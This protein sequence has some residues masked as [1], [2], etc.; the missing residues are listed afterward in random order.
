LAANTTGTLDTAAGVNA[1]SNNTTGQS[2]TAVGVNVMF[3]STT[4]SNNIAVGYRAGFNLTVGSNDIDVSNPGV[5]AESNT[6]RIGTQGAQKATFIAGI[7]NTGVTGADVLISSTGQLGVGPPSSARFKRD[8]HDME[9]ASSSLMRLRPVTF[10]YKNDPANTRQYGL[11]AEEVAKV[12]PELVVYGPDRKILTVRYS[13]LSAMLLNELQKQSR[14]NQRQAGQIQQLT[15][16]SAEQAERSEQQAV[17]NRRLSAQVAK[18]KGMFEQAMA[19]QRGA[20]SLAAAFN[21]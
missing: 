11:V 2:N 7:N 20:R 1:L 3:N 14:E 9:E 8:I 4:G 21:R 16:R 5:A 13:M 15:E 6:I 18:L 12:Y 10:V 19:A 17:Q